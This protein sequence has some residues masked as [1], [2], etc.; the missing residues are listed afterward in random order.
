ML[1]ETPTNVDH[2]R[3]IALFVA[4]VDTLCTLGLSVERSHVMLQHSALHF[5]ETVRLFDCF[6]R[7]C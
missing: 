6:V 5:Y 7:R 1:K 4:Y 2:V 3:T